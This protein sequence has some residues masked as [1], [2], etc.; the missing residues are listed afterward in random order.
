MTAGEVLDLL[1]RAEAA[2]QALA[3][4]NARIEKLEPYKRLYGRRKDAGYFNE[5]EGWR[6]RSETAEARAERLAGA[7]EDMGALIYRIDLTQA[8]REE[9][10]AEIARRIFGTDEIPDYKATQHKRV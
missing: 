3:E 6:Q 4:A 1:K 8:E 9:R 10:C 2:E 5:L 7:L